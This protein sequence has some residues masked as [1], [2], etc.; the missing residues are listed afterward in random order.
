MEL[1]N[2]YGDDA[3]ML[4]SLSCNIGSFGIVGSLIPAYESN[5]KTLSTLL[6]HSN[7]NVVE[8]AQKKIAQ[9]DK[10]IAFEKKRE[11]ENKFLYG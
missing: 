3:D 7:P 5:K 1:L 4:N 2:R 8:W 9:L 10:D 11:A 6:T